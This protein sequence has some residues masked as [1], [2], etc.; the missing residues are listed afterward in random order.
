[1]GGIRYSSKN[2]LIVLC[3]TMSSPYIDQIDPGSG[4]IIYT[5][6]GLIGD[7]ELSAENHRIANSNGTSLFYFVEVTQEPGMKKRGALDNIYKFVGKV[8]YLKHFTKVENDTTGNPRN[9]IKFI[10]EI[11]KWRLVSKEN[12]LQVRIDVNF[13]VPLEIFRSIIFFQKQREVQMQKEICKYYVHNVT[14]KSEPI[15]N[16]AGVIDLIENWK[17]RDLVF[18]R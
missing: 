8:K 15:L 11:E 16:T 6:E 18:W 7:Q 12:C 14:P 9:V 10:L 13:V 3:A 4:I 1:M 5:G 17:S 2:N